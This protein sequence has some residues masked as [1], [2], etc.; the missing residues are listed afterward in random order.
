MLTARGDEVDRVLGLELGADDYLPKP[1]FSRELVARIRTISRHTV[2]TNAT[3]TIRPAHERA[4]FNNSNGGLL[5]ELRL[6]LTGYEPQ[7]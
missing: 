4:P 1:F 6:R 2:A 5:L 3:P 7:A